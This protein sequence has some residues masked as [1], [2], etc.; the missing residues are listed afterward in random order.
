MWRKLGL[1]ITTTESAERKDATQNAYICK[2]M[3]PKDATLHNEY[4]QIKFQSCLFKIR[5]ISN[6]QTFHKT[7]IENLIVDEDGKYG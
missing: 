4:S 6:I 3:N 1:N 2:I 5:S 7:G